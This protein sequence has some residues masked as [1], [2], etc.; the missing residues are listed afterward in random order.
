MKVRL[1]SRALQLG[2]ESLGSPTVP[3][4]RQFLVSILLKTPVPLWM[5]SCKAR[6]A[7]HQMTSQCAQY[8]ELRCRLL[9]G[10]Q[11]QDQQTLQVSAAQMVEDE[12]TYLFNFSPCNRVADSALLAG[13]IKLVKSLLSCEGVNKEEVGALIIPQ[14]LTSYLFPA[15]KLIAEGGLSSRSPGRQRLTGQDIS[16]QLDTAEARAAGYN[17]LTELAKDCAS[18]LSLICRE[19][20][21]LHHQYDPAMVREHGFEYEPAIERR[22]PASNFVGLKNAGA[23]CY[24]NSVLQ[25]LYCV[26]GLAEQV[27]GVEVDTVD[28][29]SVFYQLQSVFGHLLESR[30][31]HY[32]PDRFWKC[33]KLW[34]QPVNVREQQD[35]FEFFT[36]ILDQVDEHLSAQTKEKIFSKQFEGVFSDQKICDG[37]PHRYEREQSFMALNLTV[38]SPT[39]QESL[40]QFVKGE[41][42]DGDNAYFCEKCAVKRNTTKRMCIRSLPQTLVIQL[43]RFHYDWET[44]RAVK[45]DDYFEF[46]WVL[47]MRPYTAQGIQAEE[48]RET[49]QAKLG[50]AGL[51]N[52]DETQTVSHNYDLVGV[53]VHSG[54]AS[55]G[56]YYSFIKDRRGNSVTN[57]NKNK[58]FKFN[59]TTVEE[60]EMTQ[61]NLEAECFGGKFKVKKK[62]GSNLPE[63][64]QRYWNGYILIYE[65]REDHKTP[66]TPKKS[67]SGTSHRR[68]V[69]PGM[70]RCVITII[71]MVITVSIMF[72]IIFMVTVVADSTAIVVSI[73][74]TS[75]AAIVVIVVIVIIIIINII[76]S[77]IVIIIIIILLATG[78]TSDNAVSYLGARGRQ[79]QHGQV[80]SH[81]HRSTYFTIQF[82][83][84]EL[85]PAVGPSGEG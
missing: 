59:D 22:S 7:S 62:E 73:M 20:A 13:H 82:L 21:S 18:N 44:N 76:I 47:D 46:P 75:V 39:L 79:Q 41:L 74:I 72:L 84:G 9:Q 69:G 10:M 65:A 51:A 26:P 8:F 55:A 30:L 56:H 58:W 28:E 29:D 14:F 78:A 63:E 11:L 3:Q 67:F 53:V 54:Q 80:T 49:W 61:E 6:T 71:M 31:Q 66:R 5:P 12:V 60:F 15:S 45:F 17:L 50:S 35:A 16:P 68:S 70:V 42:L 43:K 19:L 85:E 33:F 27:L 4:P 81:S 23:T 83:Q 34:G 25:Q 77:I 32:V 38:K 1:V 48:D 2:G 64:R 52:L 24:M 40:A 37:C 36:Q 57:P